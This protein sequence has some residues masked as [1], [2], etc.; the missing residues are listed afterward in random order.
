[1][2][3]PWGISGPAFAWIYGVCAV[4]PLA[5]AAANE[6][7]L[8]RD[9]GV[10][11]GPGLY[12]L[13]ALAGGAERVTDTAVAGLIE[14]H[15]LRPDGRGLLHPIRPTPADPFE[16]AVVSL[17]H[18]HGITLRELRS[19]MAR[20]EVVL[21]LRADLERKGLSVAE[22]RRRTGWLLALALYAAVLALGIARLA[23][24]IPLERAHDI[25]VFLILGVVC[26]L[27][28][29]VWGQWPDRSGRTTSAGRLALR[30]G[31]WD[32]DLARTLT[33]RVALNGVQAFPDQ[34]VAITLIRTGGTK[35]RLFGGTASTCGGG[36]AYFAAS[37][38]GGGGSS[39]GGGGSSCGGG[40]GGGCGG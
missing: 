25:L 13:A 28:V 3:E 31:D 1:M 18:G 11:K 36:A 37:S 30:Y 17:V 8:R 40:G 27:I 4:L 33:G 20:H 2:N 22:N 39:C 6:L 26:A 38:C 12:H 14:R 34:V 23:N 5:L 7:W 21:E 19:R 29:T 10:R 16:R 35:G 24:A 32:R 9:T 15:S